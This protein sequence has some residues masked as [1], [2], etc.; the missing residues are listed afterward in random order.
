MA[1]SL[2]DPGGIGP[3][4][5]REAL[6]GGAGRGM[7][8]VVYGPSR[9]LGA[10]RWP[11]VDKPDGVRPDQAVTVCQMEPDDGRP[12][13]PAPTAAQGWLSHRQVLHAIEAT[14]LPGGHPAR[15]RAICTG[16]ISKAAWFAAGLTEH[17]GHTELLAER[18]G[19]G[20]WAMAF[21]SRPLRVVL[22]TAHVPLAQVPGLV[23]AESVLQ[24]IELGHGLCL[25]LGLARPRLAVAGL[26][27]H[28]GEGGALG[29]EDQQ[30]IEPA[31]RRA[32]AMGIDAH[33]PL[34]GDTV[35]RQAVGPHRRY[36]LVVAMY[37]D[38]ALAPL[39][40]VAF[41]HAVNL[42]LGLPV[43]RT[44]PD[45][46]T[47]FDLVQRG[48]APDPGSMAHALRLAGRLARARAG[49]PEADR[50]RAGS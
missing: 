7:R 9:A 16:P 40:L 50:T 42:T 19:A 22:V 14:R 25:S 39:K 12:F 45:H 47:A 41:D 46:G 28:A 26:N 35:F 43:P 24:A 23:T 15:A 13:E 32:Q 48:Q 31:V 6:L 34:P 11:V 37:H 27:P 8:V 3:I 1:V 49:S 21:V 29:R 44:S 5:L 20:R 2:G 18:L 10:H 33:G 36:D 38:Q 4:V 17:P 30:R